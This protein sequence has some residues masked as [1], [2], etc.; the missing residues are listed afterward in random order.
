MKAQPVT[1]LEIG[2]TLVSLDLIEKQFHCDIEK[3][4]GA[5]CVIGESG[6]PLEPAE[7]EKIADVYPLVRQFMTSEGVKAVDEQGWYVIDEDGDTVTPLMNNGACAYIYED[8]GITFC[9]IEKAW[10]EGLIDFRKPVS[11]HLYPV[12][13]TEYEAYDAVNYEKNK[14]CKAALKKGKNEQV[15]LY[16]FLKDALIRKYG[17]KWYNELE[18]NA[19]VWE[20]QKQEAQ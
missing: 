10:M 19:R 15:Q 9:A 7:K 5:C 14:I 4:H 2:K 17:E 8:N 6:A 18:L 11:C 12:R 20:K 13:I 3:C 1:M 16:K